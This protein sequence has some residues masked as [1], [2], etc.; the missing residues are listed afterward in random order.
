M[1]KRLALTVL[2]SLYAVSCLAGQSLV[3]V[4]NQAVAE[5]SSAEEMYHR[6]RVILDAVKWGEITWKTEAEAESL[7]VFFELMLSSARE[8]ESLSAL[9]AVSFDKAAT[10]WRCLA[11]ITREESPDNRATALYNAGISADNAL[12]CREMGAEFGRLIGVILDIT[13]ELDLWLEEQSRDDVPES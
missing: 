10:S 3:K 13:E 1:K 2:F 8:G 9:A 7:L 11:E 5:T 4:W 6:A 12:K